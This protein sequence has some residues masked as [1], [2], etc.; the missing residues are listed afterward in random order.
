MT[1]IGSL[2]YAPPA[3]VT[4]T[5]LVRRMRGASQAQLVEASD[6]NSYVVK[7]LGNP[8][9][10]RTL[11]NEL[12]THRLLCAAGVSTPSLRQLTLPDTQDLRENAYFIVGADRLPVPVGNHF[13]SMCP[14]D[15]NTV[16]IFDF[17]PDRL[18]GQVSNFEEF[19]TMFV[20]D[21]W[22]HKVGRRQA[23][24]YRNGLKSTKSPFR[25]CFIDHGMSFGGRLW[26]LNSESLNRLETQQSIYARLNMAALTQKTIDWVMGLPQSAIIGLAENIPREWM[27]PGDAQCLAAVLGQLDR[28]RAT[29]HSLVASHLDAIDNSAPLRMH[30]GFPIGLPPWLTGATEGDISGSALQAN[31]IEP[32]STS[33]M[34][35][36][37]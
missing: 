24:Y 2:V 33:G 18:L 28:N 4:I 34:D 10:N 35:A 30:P 11:V 29:L 7:F 1:S 20:L 37:A 27:A 31:G 14:T 36:S 32:W 26:E 16:A 19:A 17:L 25:A 15:P 12:I 5:R 3:T 23:V 22:L 9:G 6:G 21:C 8:K 13:G